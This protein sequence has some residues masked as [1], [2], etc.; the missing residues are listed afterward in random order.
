[1]FIEQLP[2]DQATSG[3]QR[4]H[5]EPSLHN[6][7]NFDPDELCR[8]LELYKQQT[9]QTKRLTEARL[10]EGLKAGSLLS[11]YSEREKRLQRVT[12]QK[13]QSTSKPSHTHRKRAS[14][15]ETNSRADVLTSGSSSATEPFPQRASYL[16]QCAAVDFAKTTTSDSSSRA[17][18]LNRLSAFQQSH[19]QTLTEANRRA[20]IQEEAFRILSGQTS[21][22]GFT[23][24]ERP[25]YEKRRPVSSMASY[26]PS[27]GR[28]KSSSMRPN[29]AAT[30]GGI[31]E[32]PSFEEY[33]PSTILSNE[34][35]GEQGHN[36]NIQLHSPQHTLERHHGLIKN[37]KAELEEKSRLSKRLSRMIL[38]IKKSE[39][40]SESHY[41][42]KPVH[43]PSAKR[44]SS[45][46]GLFK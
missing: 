33:E 1:M 6:V 26:G 8:R 22:E 4:R 18:T 45:F 7:E 29:T 20:S 25:Q 13:H 15:A 19:G 10:E 3:A 12:D 46:L 11:T 42:D 21:E 17:K 27:H 41:T 34:C 36:E 14:H 43:S 40:Q 23:N 38:N 9:R 28:Q 31:E 37:D 24:N 16:P 32:R 35:N 5:T 2:A 44:R 30:F 39:P